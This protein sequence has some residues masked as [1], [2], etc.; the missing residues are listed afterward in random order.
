MPLITVAIP[1]RNRPEGLRAALASVLSQQGMDLEVVVSD[2]GASPESGAGLPADPRVRFFKQDRELSMVENWNF[3]L[4]K[5]DG[6]YFLLLSDDDTLLPGALSGLL[7]AA[8]A[9]GISLSYGRARFENENASFLGLSAPA[10]A[11]ETGS[12]FIRAS[13]EG[14]RQALPSFTLFRTAAARAGGGYPATGN[15]T[16]LALRLCLALDGDVACF[17]GPAGV[18]RIHPASL[19]CDLD[20]MAESFRALAAWAKLSPLAALEPEIRG[21]CAASLRLHARACALRGDSVGADKLYT[22]AAGISAPAWHEPLSRSFWGSA[23]VRF[24]A[25]LRRNVLSGLERDRD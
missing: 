14:K 25:A 4:G 19:T 24:L 10:P 21:Y 1:T 18:Y 3:C 11:R 8:R 6:E 5:A 13:L 12:D 15:S 17:P 22:A 9:E 2:N 7:A 20:K 23:P 16:D